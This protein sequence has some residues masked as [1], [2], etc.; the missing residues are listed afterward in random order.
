MGPAA[1]MGPVEEVKR[2]GCE[3]LSGD[4]LREGTRRARQRVMFGGE[5]GATFGGVVYVG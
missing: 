2:C 1:V 3:E 4:A 5:G